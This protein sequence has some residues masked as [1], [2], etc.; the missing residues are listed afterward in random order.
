MAEPTWTS[1]EQTKDTAGPP[2]PRAR[3]KRPPALVMLSGGVAA[4]ILVL[5]VI[6]SWI[7]PYDP[8]HQDLMNTAAR[9]GGGHLL[10][11]D[12]LGRDVLSLLIAGAHTAVVGPVVVAVGAVLLGSTLGMLA[13]WSGGFLDTAMSR[14][15]DLMYALPGLLV[16]VVVVGVLE[17]GYW[18][19]VAVLMM[20][21]VPTAFRLTRSV[22]SAQVRLPY[23]EA[24]R[25]LG[26]P[27]R[28]IIF[29]HILPN[30]LPTILATFLLDFV[31]ALIGLS[32]LSFLGLGAPP[33]A[34][35][36]GSLLQDGQS[37]LTVNPWVSLAPGLLI[38]LTATSVT[39]LGD[40]MYERYSAEGGLR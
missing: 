7:T 24:A 19:A 20:L 18:L 6:G 37:M 11:T 28:R 12:T 26:L 36:W 33:G 5:V 1:L 40:W 29:R 2:V 9:P 23:V 16:I 17:G 14:V 21:S 34:P 38:V 31:G 8:L 32:G 39:L 13:G 27:T 25:T 3:R 35:D 10:G 15:A 4:A 22:A 30:I